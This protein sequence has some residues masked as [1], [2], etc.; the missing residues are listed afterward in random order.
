MRGAK[1]KF[2]IISIYPKNYKILKKIMFHSWKS[3]RRL[4][5]PLFVSI[6]LKLELN[7][8][9]GLIQKFNLFNLK[10]KVNFLFQII[11]DLDAV[12]AC[13][14]VNCGQGTCREIG[15]ALFECDCYPGWTKFN[16]FPFCIIP[17]CKPSYS[18]NLFNFFGLYI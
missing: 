18:S 14:I 4:F 10:F 7:Y 16:P 17:N 2:T 11:S 6:Y 3:Q 13:A 8:L 15:D 9:I 12:N 1:C 5:I